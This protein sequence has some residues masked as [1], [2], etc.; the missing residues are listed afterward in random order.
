M[1]FQEHYQQKVLPEMMKQFGYLNPMAVPRIMKVSL[2]VGIGRDKS[3]EKHVNTVADTL[4]RITG[5]KPVWTKAKKS[6]AAFK[7]REGQTVGAKVTLRGKRMEDFLYKLISVALPRIHDF[8]GLPASAVDQ[9][10]NL[11]IGFREHLAFPEIR[12]DEVERIHGL[13][14]SIHCTARTRD[15]GF[16]FFKLLGFPFQQEK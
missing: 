2:N 5:Q 13:E 8:R 10:G 11:T 6:I 1:T 14:V 7:I 3:D 16:A 9:S 4:T 12:P 15:E